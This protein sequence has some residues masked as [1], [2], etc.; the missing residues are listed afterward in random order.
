MKKS[1]PILPGIFSSIALSKVLTMIMIGMNY[2]I[3]EEMNKV[4]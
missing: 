3:N 1:I 4:K 2:T